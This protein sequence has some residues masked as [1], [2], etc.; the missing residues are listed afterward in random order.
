MS[1]TPLYKLRT[2]D[3]VIAA[4]PNV[5]PHLLEDGVAQGLLHPSLDSSGT[6]WYNGREL[7]DFLV[8]EGVISR[9]V[10]NA[11]IYQ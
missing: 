5:T 1:I 4:Y 3:E 10:P 7:F 8:K 2:A 9:G 11:F 6:D